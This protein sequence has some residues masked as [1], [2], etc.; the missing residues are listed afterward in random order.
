MVKPVWGGAWPVGRSAHAACCLNYGQDHPQ[1]LLHGGLDNRY[2]T[3][4]DMWILDVDTVKWTEVSLIDP[5]RV[6]GHSSPSVV[7]LF[8]VYFEYAYLAATALHLQHG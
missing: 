8:A 1:L 3:L 5:R 4:G 2:K 7:C 6:G